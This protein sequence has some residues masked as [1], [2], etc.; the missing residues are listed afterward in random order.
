MCECISY[1][2]L[3]MR[4]LS[5][6]P[7]G[8]QRIRRTIRRTGPLRARRRARRR[9][10][11][12]SNPPLKRRKRA[13]GQDAGPASNHPLT[14][15]TSELSGKLLDPSRSIRCHVSRRIHRAMHRAICQ[16]SCC[17]GAAYDPV[18]KPQPAGTA[19]TDPNPLDYSL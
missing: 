16:V 3:P 8:K 5:R 12:E 13:V 18:L 4:Q 1:L 2:M 14:R 10:C 6:E 19:D 11:L 7:F 9:A 15:Y 17:R